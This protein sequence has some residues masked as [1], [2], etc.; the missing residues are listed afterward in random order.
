MPEKPAHVDLAKPDSAEILADGVRTRPFSARLPGSFGHTGYICEVANSLDPT[1]PTQSSDDAWIQNVV[2]RAL[3]EAKQADAPGRRIDVDPSATDTGGTSLASST[4]M[5]SQVPPSTTATELTRTDNG[6]PNEVGSFGTTPTSPVAQISPPAAQVSPSPAAQTSQ[7]TGRPWSDSIR[8]R[9]A[10]AAQA[11]QRLTTTAPAGQSAPQRTDVGSTVTPN[12]SVTEAALAPNQPA[13]SISEA[14]LPSQARDELYT[15]TIPDPANS[16]FFDSETSSTVAPMPVDGAASPVEPARVLY[17]FSVE[18]SPTDA[19]SSDDTNGDAA[20]GDLAG[21]SP[22]Y[23]FDDVMVESAVST[24]GFRASNLRTI[25]EWLAVVGSALAVALLIKAFVLQAFWIPTES[26]ETTVNE[27]DR[28]L[29]NKLSYRLHEVRRGD[30]VVFRKIEGTPG[31]TD[32]LI[33]RAIAL[34][35]ETIEV[36]DDGRIWIWGPGETPEDALL[37]DEPYLDPQNALL[38]VPSASAPVSNDIWNERCTNNRTPGRCTLDDSSYFMLGDNR[39]ASADSRFFGPV[40]DE[41][42]VGRAFLRIWPLGDI[43]T[44]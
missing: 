23:A 20:I 31:D 41:N 10:E 37:L 8:A 44:L 6:V 39:T 15:T 13:P 22:L 29:V 24:D 21:V 11:S 14:P 40:P 16:P 25:L 30:L 28:I 26:M 27:G 18:E 3:L 42:I 2:A 43:S 34:P 1:E 36:R 32:D 7:V 38:G 9:A 17:G 12:A 4:A 33:K 35:G 5:P 19:A